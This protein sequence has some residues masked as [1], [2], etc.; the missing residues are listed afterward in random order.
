MSRSGR[1]SFWPDAETWVQVA[2]DLPGFDVVPITA[3]VAID[4]AQ[5]PGKLH[6]DTANRIIICIA[7]YLGEPVC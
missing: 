6:G 5:R 1:F 3:A 7:R 2:T 4:S